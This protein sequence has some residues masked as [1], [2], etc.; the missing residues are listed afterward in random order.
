VTVWVGV[1]PGSRETGIVARDGRDLTGWAVIDRHQTEPGTDRPG[2]ATLAEIEAAVRCLL[3]DGARVAVEEYLPPNPHVSWTGG[4]S[5]VTYRDAINTA[6][7]IGWMLRAFPD[8]VLIAPG[9]HGSQLLATY[10][11]ALVTDREYAHAVRR[12]TL[13]RAAPQNSA[14]RHARSAW[15]VAGSAA[16]ADRLH[17]AAQ[18]PR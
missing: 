17:R 1:D 14:M 16:M 11:R 13:T 8:A 12:R 5:T 15:D 3:T 4:R 10:P 6:L 2:H 9:G 18:R 7:V